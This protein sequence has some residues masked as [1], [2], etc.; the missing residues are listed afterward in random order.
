[1]ELSK[2]A[3]L[4]DRNENLPV[5]PHVA[6][7]VLQRADDEGVSARGLEQ[8]IVQD[9]AIAG[10]IL[11]VANS[12]AYGSMHAQSIERAISIIGLPQMKRLVLQACLQ[13][14]MFDQSHGALPYDQAEYWRHS[15][16]VSIA[17]R[18]LAKHRF[19]DLMDE[20]TVAGMLHDVGV[21][22]ASRFLS[23]S[24]GV[25]IRNASEASVPLHQAELMTYG[26]THAAVGAL[27]VKRWGLSPRL[28]AGIEYHHSAAGDT[29]F[30][31]TTCLI[32]VADY[33]A[34]TV[35][36]PGVVATPGE[37]DVAASMTIGVE[38]VEIQR[39]GATVVEEVLLA[40]ETLKIA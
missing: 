38:E 35:G 22:V 6:R 5:F 13:S 39:I 18:E 28:I 2:I 19:P 33:I 29:E 7:R 9:A 23:D 40:Q 3:I 32:S 30:Y 1:M 37:L 27:T 24:Y 8:I 31:E 17:A 34:H 20:L 16:A 12:S 15:L 25:V 14:M 26:W 36:L 11:K 4:I 10:K 21:L